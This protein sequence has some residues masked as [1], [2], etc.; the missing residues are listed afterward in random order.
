MQGG[1]RM[2]G[3]DPALIGNPWTG[4]VA[5]WPG[6]QGN[7]GQTNY[8]ALNKYTPFDP[9][10][11]D[12]VSERDGGIYPSP[13]TYLKGGGKK[14]RKN[15]GGGLL[16]QDLVNMGRS[17]SYGFGSAYNSLQGYPAPVDPLPYKDQYANPN[18]SGF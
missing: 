4:K 2:G 13:F 15:K 17:V 9:Q 18:Y 3:S 11:Q 1:M 10:T 6:V 8:F 16:P 5:D 7:D 12:V 14:S